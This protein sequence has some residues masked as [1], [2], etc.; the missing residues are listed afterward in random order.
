LSSRFVY[1]NFECFLDDDGQGNVRIY[2]FD[3]SKQKVIINATAGTINYNTGTV[4]V[5]NFAITSYDG[6]ELYITC[7]TLNLDVD[8]VR[9]QILIVDPKDATVSIIDERLR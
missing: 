6:I 3:D 2:R 5:P 7:E 1:R 4:D 8:P 9:E